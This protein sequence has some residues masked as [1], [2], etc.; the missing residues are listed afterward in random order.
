MPTKTLNDERVKILTLEI[1][2]NLSAA[3]RVLF[4]LGYYEVLN[5][6][7]PFLATYIFRAELNSVI[8][9]RLLPVIC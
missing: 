9:N 3:L 8:A 2:K 6:F 5:F 4:K 7:N 1:N